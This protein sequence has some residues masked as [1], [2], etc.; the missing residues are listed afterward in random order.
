M[1][2]RVLEPEVMDTAEEARDYDS[3]DHSHVNQLFVADFLKLGSTATSVLE[4]GAGT[5]Q[6]PI[7]LCQTHPTVRV[8]AIDLANEMLAVGRRNL[9][10]TGLAD[11]IEL[12]LVDAKAMPFADA[13]FNAVISNSIVHHI[14]EPLAVFA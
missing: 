7:T 3:M 5:A 9:A 2:P 14:P 1:L 8:I 13:S 6:I 11:R 4:V 10:R 12:Q